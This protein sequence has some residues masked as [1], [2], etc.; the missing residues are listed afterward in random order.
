MQR[1]FVWFGEFRRGHMRIKNIAQWASKR[2]CYGR[3]Q[4]KN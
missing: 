2:E 1:N 3:K 4:K